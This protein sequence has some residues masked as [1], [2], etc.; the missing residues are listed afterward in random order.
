MTLYL[1]MFATSYFFDSVVSFSSCP[2]PNFV[3]KQLVVKSSAGSLFASANNNPPTSTPP[4]PPVERRSN[5]KKRE[6]LAIHKL[7]KAAYR[8]Y[9]SYVRRLWRETDPA[10][11]TLVANDKIRGAI[12]NVQHILSCNEYTSLSDKGEKSLSELLRACDTMLLALSEEQKAQNLDDF[13]KDLEVVATVPTVDPAKKKPRRSIMFGVIMGIAVACWVFSGNYV[14]TALFTLMTILGQLE[15]YRMIM[16]TGVYPARRISVIGASSMFLTVS[17]W[18]STIFPLI[19]GFL[20]LY[21]TLVLGIVCAQSSSDLS[22]DVWPLG[23]DLVPHN[24]TIIHHYSRDCS[25]IYWHVLSWLCPFILGTPK[26][27]RRRYGPN[28]PP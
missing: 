7:P 18:Q 5:F 9:M 21:F 27:T 25:Y 12:R 14:F 3:L 23:D 22:T 16:S 11:R 2:M 13:G 15:Y 10:A 1:L 20:M 17:W 26:I 4:Q 24:E 6:A 28:A 8:V 19:S